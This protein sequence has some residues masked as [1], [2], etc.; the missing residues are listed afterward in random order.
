MRHDSALHLYE[1]RRRIH[2]KFIEIHRARRR[3]L[4]EVRRAHRAFR[5]QPRRPQRRQQ[6]ADQNRD[7]PGDH[8]KLDQRERSTSAAGT[9]SFHAHTISQR[10]TVP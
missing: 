6:D 7:D 3:E 8:Q 2:A 4:T 9:P 5:R 10:D 1:R